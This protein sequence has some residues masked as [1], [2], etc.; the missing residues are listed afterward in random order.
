MDRILLGE[1]AQRAGLVLTAAMLDQ[2]V[3]YTQLLKEANRTMNLTSI[4]EDQAVAILH[5]ED[6]WQPA[7]HIPQGAHLIDVGTG[8]GFPGMALGIIRPDLQVTLLDATLKKVKFLQQVIDALQLDQVRAVQGRAEELGRTGAYREQF[9]LAL[10]R[11]LT[12]LPALVE[13]CLPFVKP[14][15]YLIAMKG[16][17]DE[18]KEASRAIRLLHGSLDRVIPYSLPGIDRPRSLVMIR[19]TGPTPPS[20]PRRMAVIKK[21]PL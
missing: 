11:A 8:A 17:E 20:Y 6:S 10:A 5:F 18:T 3:R 12:A 13:L 4:T 7:A 21:T 19:K 9:D 14:G 2:A 15:G 1:A 16:G